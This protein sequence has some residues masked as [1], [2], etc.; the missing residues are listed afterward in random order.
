MYDLVL[1]FSHG[2]IFKVQSPENAFAVTLE[3]FWG[4]SNQFQNFSL[5]G[6]CK[7]ANTKII[8]HSVGSQGCRIQPFLSS[9]YTEKLNSFCITGLFFSFFFFFQRILI[10]TIIATYTS[11]CLIQ[12]QY[13][14]FYVIYG[15]IKLWYVFPPF[16]FFYFHSKI[17][18]SFILQI[19]SK[20]VAH[21]NYT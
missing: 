8:S 13:I 9:L 5:T 2:L 18:P 4:K 17:S 7:E 6:V 14:F 20:F 3:A 16:L 11:W 10:C 12:N 15:L 19:V 1:W 21:L